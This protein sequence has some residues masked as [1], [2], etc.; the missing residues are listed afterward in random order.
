MIYILESACNSKALENLLRI[1]KRA[2]SLIQIIGPILA[3]I[4]LVFIFI[5]LTANP[6]NKKL[7]KNL[8]NALIA[9][10]ILF[11]VPIIINVTMKLLDDSFS[12]SDCW[13]NISDERQEASYIEDENN[14]NQNII[15]DPN[16][17][18]KG[19]DNKNNTSNNNN[20]NNNSTSNNN[21]NSS[22]QSNVSMSRLDIKN[23][24]NFVGICY[25]TWFNPIADSAQLT[26]TPNKVNNNFYY[27]GEPALGFY[28]SDDK[29]VIKT[30][31]QQLADA[32]I[33]FI[34]IDNTNAQTSWKN[35]SYW[36][37]MITSSNTALL[38]TIVQMNASGLKTPRVLNWINTN[39][40]GDVVKAIYDEF[41]T[42]SKYKDVW[43]YY[44]GKPFILTTTSYSSSNLTT[45]KMWGLQTSLST[46]EWSYLQINNDL[47]ARNINGEIEQIGVSV[48][49]QSTYMSNTATAIGRRKGET[50][51]NQWKTAFKYHPKVVTITWWNEW[52]AQY[53]NGNFTDEY[54][55]EY[56]RDIEPMK[57]GHGSKYYEMMKRYI[58][59]YKANST[60]PHY[61]E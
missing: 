15:G 14:N 61:N 17:Y 55:Q 18:E 6:E 1:V 19:K 50:F 28:R 4:S 33:D 57:G 26:S 48:A 21:S 35:S 42:N 54:N 13:N 27:W 20:N 56:S 25:S 47:P 9:L 39:N 3:I 23:G 32:G 44:E 8:K 38:D 40:G 52:A 10:V 16:N 11:F 41:Y 60:C 43:V 53:I 45:R 29:S 2:L 59:A 58:Q 46:N 31:M 24:N 51:Y 12:L 37:E 34:I 30:H 5:K 7:V 36:N 49:M 22:N